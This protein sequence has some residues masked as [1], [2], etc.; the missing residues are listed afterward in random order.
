MRDT[1]SLNSEHKFPFL[2]LFLEYFRISSLGVRL[3]SLSVGHYPSVILASDL[4]KR[5]FRSM[6]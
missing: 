2:Y 1:S 5:A 4:G 3:Y 6:V